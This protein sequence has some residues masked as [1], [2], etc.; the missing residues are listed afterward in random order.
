MSNPTEGGVTRAAADEREAREQR[1]EALLAD[2]SVDPAC[3]STDPSKRYAAILSAVI[4][5]E[6]TAASSFDTLEEAADWL[7]TGY[8]NDNPRDP[9]WV[10]DL[11]TGEG[12]QPSTVV[13]VT[14]HA[15]EDTK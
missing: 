12:Y 15:E 4:D 8:D 7:A 14:L 6:A 5:G 11:D 2:Y 9:T 10:L 13:T 3:N 1:L